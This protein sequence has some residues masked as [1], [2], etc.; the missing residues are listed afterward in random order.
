VSA[1]QRLA[2]PLAQQHH[3]AQIVLVF[4]LQQRALADRPVQ[5]LR[6]MPGGGAQIGAQRPVA[7]THDD[8]VLVDDRRS[9]L[10]V[11][12]L[13]HRRHIGHRQC[14]GLLG[15]GQP[16]P[17]DVDGAQP[18]GLHLGQYFLLRALAPRQQVTMSQV[19]WV[20]EAAPAVEPVAPAPPAPPLS[21]HNCFFCFVGPV[22]D[23][24]G[25]LGAILKKL[26][27]RAG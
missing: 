27:D 11:R 10:H 8:A 5:R 20:T 1:E 14:P 4:R 24:S 25:D 7:M 19:N 2:H 17:E 18:E 3:L 9:L 21:Q 15:V 6:E 13:L 23:Y 12:H 26:L 16:F 22:F